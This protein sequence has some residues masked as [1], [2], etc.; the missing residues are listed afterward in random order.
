[1]IILLFNNAFRN[2]LVLEY[3]TAFHR[4]FVQI[5]IIELIFPRLLGKKNNSEYKILCLY[6]I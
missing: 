4:F 1:M 6:T 2:V 3:F 5:Y